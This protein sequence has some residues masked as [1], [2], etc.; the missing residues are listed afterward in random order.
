MVT[1]CLFALVL[2]L[3]TAGAASARA[4]DFRDP[5]QRTTTNT[6][7]TLATNQWSVDAGLLGVQDTDLVARVGLGYGLGRGFSL[8]T[9]FGHS[10]VGILNLRAKW[11]FLDR[12]GFGLGVS[13]AVFWGHG[14]WM[15]IVGED[16]SAVNVVAVPLSLHASFLPLSWLQLDV[17]ASYRHAEVFGKVD[18]QS[19]FVDSRIGLRSLLVRLVTRFYIAHKLELVLE[20]RLPLYAALPG[21]LETEAELAEGVRAGARA[22][23]FQRLEFVDVFGAGVGVRSAIAKTTFI[24]AS[25]HY[26][27]QVHALYG[28]S[29][30]PGM[31]LEH[32]F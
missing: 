24:S 10:A 26:G 12:P 13:L 11:N 1:R 29:F 18:T 23:G 7:Y 28:H 21:Q 22:A 2:L 32:R 9:N 8:D 17:E 3:G 5:A 6:A 4:R 30:W 19:L 31:G 14:A 16:L 15:W 20:A 25:I 27:R